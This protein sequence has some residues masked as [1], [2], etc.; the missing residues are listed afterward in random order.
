MREVRFKRGI[1]LPVPG[2]WLDARERMPLSFVSHAHADHMARHESVIATPETFRLMEARLAPR[3]APILHS[4]RETFEL[5]KGRARLLPAGHIFGSAQF[6]YQDEGGSVLYTGDF[7]LR[8]SRSAEAFEGVKAD[9]LIM[10]TT[11]GLPKYE[12]PPV[13]AVEADV[14]RFCGETLSDG[15]T[16]VLLSYSLGKTQEAVWTLL[17]NGFTPML[18][19][20]GYRMTELCRSLGSGTP[21]GYVPFNR[22]CMEDK[23][24]ILPPCDATRTQLRKLGSK[25]R[26]AVLTGWAL[27]PGVTFRY[28]TDE[29]FAWSDHA[30]YTEL[31]RCVEL[32]QPQVVYTVHGF[33][34]AFASD[35]RKRGVEAW[36]LSQQNQLELGL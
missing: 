15:K 28:Q 6:F 30:D 3:S 16:P 35:L 11:F 4:Y 10:E 9:I 22:D 26:S 29:A 33:A 34:A 12:L 27:D 14:M 5:G 18:H 23:V 8:G 19:P 36:A 7:K 1:H 24:L 32:V 31:L 20:Q 13:E 21:A 25:V 17:Q 2:L